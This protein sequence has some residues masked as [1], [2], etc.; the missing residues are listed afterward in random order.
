[1]K[2]KPD[3]EPTE[4][5]NRSFIWKP[6]S[7][8]YDKSYLSFGFTS[9]IIN[10]QERPQCVLCLSILAADSMKSNKLKRNLETKHSEMKNKPEEYF[11]RK[12]DQICIQQKSFVNN[13]TVSSRALFASYK[14]SY[15]IPQNE[16]TR[17]PF[18]NPNLGMRSYV[19]RG[20]HIRPN[21]PGMK[22]IFY[23]NPLN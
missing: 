18:Q 12:R 2:R 4:N 19:Q 11:H 10:S 17:T 5:G 7:R 16:S 22:R 3:H 13:T 8:K 6:K 14:A 20:N 9:V 15:R 1:M 23:F 21:N